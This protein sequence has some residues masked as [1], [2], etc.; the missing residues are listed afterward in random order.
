MVIREGVVWKGTPDGRESGGWETSRR[1]KGFIG[2]KVNVCRRRGEKEMDG[3][4]KS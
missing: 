1:R 2:E 4:G 3:M